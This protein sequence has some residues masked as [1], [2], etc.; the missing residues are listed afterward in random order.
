MWPFRVILLAA[1]LGGVTVPPP[2]GQLMLYNRVP[3]AGSSTMKTLITI[4][5]RIHGYTHVDKAYHRADHAPTPAKV[6]SLIHQLLHLDAGGCATHRTPARIVGTAHFYH[7]DLRPVWNASSRVLCPH[8]PRLLPLPVYINV[9]RNPIE[10]QQSEFYYHV[11]TKYATTARTMARIN[12]TRNTT[13]EEAIWRVHALP[14]A[15]LCTWIENFFSLDVSKEALEVSQTLRYFSGPGIPVTRQEFQSSLAT[16]V[17][18][19]RK[20]YAIIG[21]TE[22]LE[23]TTRVFARVAPEFFSGMPDILRKL[24]RLRGRDMRAHRPPL[25]QAARDVLRPCLTSEL[26]LYRQ[27]YE[28]FMAQARSAGIEDVPPL[29]EGLL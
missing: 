4:L 25:S 29:P 12:L 3:K 13:F 21:V 26:E 27:G 5:A 18:N 24:G 2:V 28:Q 14:D 20:H 7:V 6:L 19:I 22:M 17:D 1:S 23:A 10:R 9:I 11:D 15:H 16:S 8:A